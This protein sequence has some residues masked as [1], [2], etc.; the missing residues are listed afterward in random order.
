MAVAILSFVPTPAALETSTGSL[1]FLRSRA[2]RAPKLP[3]P[4]STQGVNVRLAWW[5]ILCLAS[6]ATAIF[7]PASAYFMKD[8]SASISDRGARPRSRFAMRKSL[9]RR[10]GSR[11]LLQ[12]ETFPPGNLECPEN[13]LPAD[14]ARM[15]DGVRIGEEALANLSRLPGFG[16]DVQRH[17]NQHRRADDIPARDAAPEA[18]VVGISAVVAH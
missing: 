2:K 12:R 6:S 16:G 15:E 18:A 1:H 5:R 3:M 14:D 9:E 4:P 11:R 17:I 13:P 10:G 8:L 7:T